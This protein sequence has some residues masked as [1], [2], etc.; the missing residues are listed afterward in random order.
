MLKIL[1]LGL[2]EFSKVIAPIAPF[3][4]ESIFRNLTGEESVHLQDW[5]KPQKIT[6]KEKELL[7]QMLLVRQIC[8]L[9]HAARKKEEIKV[10][11]PLG[12]LKVSSKKSIVS[13]ELIEI[14]KDELNI[15]K[16]RNNFYKR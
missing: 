8:E 3:V 9:G 12:K 6:K 7:K 10:R 16:C 11:Q 1:L 14:I 5:S 13:K 15:K 2:V 4:S